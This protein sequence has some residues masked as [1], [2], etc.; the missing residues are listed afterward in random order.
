M[1]IPRLRLKSASASKSRRGRLYRRARHALACPGLET[2]E[3]RELLAADDLRLGMNLDTL[4]SGSSEW[5]FVD[6]FKL[7]SPWVSQLPFHNSPW[8]TGE[9]VQVDE[10]DYPLLREGQAAGTVMLRALD[11]AYPTGVYVATWEGDGMLSFE[12]DSKVV[13][14][15]DHR[16]ELDVSA[17]NFGVYLRIDR[18]SPANP[19]RDIKIWM[20]GFEDAQSPFHPLFVDRLKPFSTIRFMDWERT[21]NSSLVSWSD[22]TLPEDSDQTADSGVALEYQI[23]LANTV[24]ADPWF[25]MP[26]KADDDYVRNFAQ[27]VKDK[28]AP[29]RKVY[30][31]WSNEAWNTA[32]SQGDWSVAEAKK[33]F[34]DGKY[35]PWV[36]A[37]ES[38]RVWGIWKEVFGDQSDRVIRVL[39]GRNALPSLA[40]DI[41][42]RLQGE[43]DAIA[44]AP[45]ISNQAMVA[46]ADTTPTQVMDY[47]LA[48][49]ANIVLP[50]LA[51]HKALADDWSARTG[52]HIAF[53]TYE[54]GQ[55]V[56]ARGK[57]VPY[58]QALYD[59]QVHPL[60]FLAY[61]KL[62]DRFRELGGEL[63]TAFNYVSENSRFGST[64]H[65]LRQDELPLEAPKWQALMN[66]LG[67]APGP[68][69]QVSGPYGIWVDGSIVLH[70]AATP[71]P[72][73][74]DADLTFS[75]DVNG[76]GVLGDVFGPDPVV[77]WDDLQT[78][79]LA[80]PTKPW[81]ISVRVDDGVAA[82]W[83]T[84]SMQ[85]VQP[86]R[87]VDDSFQGTEDASILGNVLGNDSGGRAP[88]STTLVS[89]PSHGDVDLGIDG[90]FT[91][92]PHPQFNGPDSFVYAV[93]DA[94]GQ[95]GDATVSLGIAP[96]N[97]APV[98][99]GQATYVGAGLTTSLTLTGDDGDAEIDQSLTFAI[100]TYPE[101]GVLSDFDPATGS[102]K[103]TPDAGYVG[104]DRFSFTASDDDTAGGEALTSDAALVSLEVGRVSVA[105]TDQDDDLSITALAGGEF[106]IKL[107]DG[108]PV[109]YP[110]L[111]SLAFSGGDGADSIEVHGAPDSDRFDVGPAQL[112]FDGLSIDASE[113][114]RIDLFGGEGDDTF[115][116][117]PGIAPI[118]S[119]AGEAGDD[120]FALM[121][122]AQ[123]DGAVDGGPGSNTLDYSTWAS[124]LVVD[125]RSGSAPAIALAVSSISRVTGGAGDDRLT[126]D[127][128]A[129]V[130][131]GG[132]GADWLEGGEGDD[133]LLGGDGDDSLVGG[134]G[135]D[136][137]NGETQL[138]A[139]T[140]IV[141][142][143]SDLDLADNAYDGDLN[144][145]DVIQ[146][147][148]LAQV[149][150][151]ADRATRFQVGGWTG[152]GQLNGQS[153]AD[154]LI[155]RAD[156]EFFL[157]DDRL[158]IAGIPRPRLSGFESAR[159]VGGPGPD[160]FDLRYWTRPA[161]VDGAGDSDSL[162]ACVGDHVW[163][164]H[165]IN[166]G[167][168][169]AVDFVGVEN[170]F[171]GPN[172]D[173]FRL[174]A[175]AAIEGT[176][177]AGDGA[178]LLDFSAWTDPATVNLRTRQATNVGAFRSIETYV[179]G[180]GSDTFVGRDVDNVW[181]IQSLDAGKL[182][183][184]LFRSFETL[185]GSSKTDQFQ[186]AVRA[187]V[188][189]GI[190]G[191]DGAD[192]LDYSLWRTAVTVNLGTGA[193]SGVAGGVTNIENVY[194][195]SGADS[196]TGNSLDNI[197]DGQAGDDLVDGGPGG[198]D[199]LVGGNGADRLFAGADRAILIGGNGA[200]RLQ[201]GASEDILVGGRLYTKNF[202]AL[203]AIMAEWRRGDLAIRDRIDHLL[204]RVSGGK[205]GAFR[206]DSIRVQDD[207]NPDQLRGQGQADWFWANYSEI[208]D[209]LVDVDFVGN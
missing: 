134:L 62:F 202:V 23:E 83:R 54:G 114:E 180:Q 137:L 175:G 167:H 168:V 35:Y 86:L 150:G 41:A 73:R 206:V 102:V 205:N 14:R 165:G 53:I 2:L 30:V 97:D 3:R 82:D 63:F 20:P 93:N 9:T 89:A 17:G 76:D 181:Q 200:D 187:G 68:A 209:L 194:G 88:R 84:T 185:V 173:Q 155:V 22:R 60:M 45:Y 49:L 1:K 6:I 156:G 55:Q 131:R 107:N 40:R 5:A 124:G 108:E 193:A 146:G 164:I 101:H 144:G 75:W 148:E 162:S 37:D 120:T 8:D 56:S 103:Y 67:V 27:L 98:A 118:A 115:F 149:T 36:I 183:A 33:R 143:D 188:S 65:L 199:I 87:V 26:H 192:L 42:D 136:F 208:S 184:V 172:R 32:F 43:F 31:E 116:V 34:G 140:L 13:F 138:I 130:L 66:A 18:S 11:G 25:D 28:L 190:D 57:I 109:R 95:T 207:G 111:R 135:D 4:R 182:G 169:G 16:I 170:L 106:E 61:E 96:V 197:L 72:D 21:N 94:D 122:G 152:A 133:S 92:T 171:G 12:G 161:V 52:R 195:G 154:E 70:A 147:V 132:P 51:D 110:G 99:F 50:R 44:S 113:V 104:A 153:D 204:G 191:G 174:A 123:L 151:A 19:V 69:A 112:L 201:G 177:D 39:A 176:M 128:A 79:G 81:H 64:G 80:D 160:A 46:D 163:D 15:G 29:G 59:A 198:N 179:G 77:T 141:E 189:G 158:R 85:V 117:A 48:R 91:Y 105:G 125:L 78:L 126:G 157:A 90:A 142:G 24:G 58:Q 121:E 47:A 145:H 196:L 74:P 7:H 71:S 186:F 10:H 159:L 129:N 166:S 38:A 139:D 178:D 100:D 203:A 127:A 119:L